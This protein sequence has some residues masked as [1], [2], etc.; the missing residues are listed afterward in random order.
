MLLGDV[1]ARL[2]IINLPEVDS[3][4]VLEKA[5]ELGVVGG[6]IYDA[7]LSRC[8]LNARVG[9]LYTWNVKHFTRLGDDVASRVRRP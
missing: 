7:L 9:A 2:A 1:R 5:V 8:A 6:G 3:V 4:Q